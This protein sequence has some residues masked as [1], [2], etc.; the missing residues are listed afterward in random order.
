VSLPKTQSGS[1][2]LMPEVLQSDM[3]IESHIPPWNETMLSLRQYET[4][5]VRAA[6]RQ[7]WKTGFIGCRLRT[8]R[9]PGL[10]ASATILI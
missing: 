7:P 4:S 2:R 5:L 3:N 6:C 8:V 9:P 10:W 1:L